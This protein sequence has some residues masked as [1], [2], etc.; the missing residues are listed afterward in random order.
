MGQSAGHGGTCDTEVSL[1]LLELLG[2]SSPPLTRNPNI[3]ET[4]NYAE[5]KGSLCKKQKD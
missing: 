1:V 4:E 3:W 5:F 2:G